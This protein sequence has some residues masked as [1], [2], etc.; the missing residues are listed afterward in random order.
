MRIARAAAGGYAF[1][2]SDRDGWVSGAAVGVSAHNLEELV[3]DLSAIEARVA[4][5]EPDLP[6]LSGSALGAPV[7]RPGKILAVG[8]N[9]LQHIA[10]VGKA[11]P[12]SP[13]I[14]AKYPSAVTGPHDP[15]ELN[16]TVTSEVDYE[17]ELAVVIGRRAR[18]VNVDQALA[19]VLGYCVANDV[20]ARDVQRQESQVSRSKGL[21]TFCPLG[22]WITTTQE[23]ADPHGLWIRTTVNGEIRQ[24][25]TTAD[26]L[27]S[28][29]ALIAH[30]SRTTTLEPG[31]VILTG[32]PSG[33]G[34][35]MTPPTYLKEQDVVTCEIEKLGRIQNRVVAPAVPQ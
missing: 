12:M 26:L 15:I 29:P 18:N 3:A 6:D 7:P 32:T 8:L 33:V 16:P 23:V 9:Y 31:D 35:G 21:D 17:A 10:E 4:V 11:P 28:V 22:P 25:S 2:L 27:F 13:M 1:G 5:A 24:D 20:S 14:F 30:L 19:H 34:S